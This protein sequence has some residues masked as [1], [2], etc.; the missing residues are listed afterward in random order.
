[1]KWV[2]GSGLIEESRQKSVTQEK[3]PGDRESYGHLSAVD[4]RVSGARD[5]LRRRSGRL[6][7]R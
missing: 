5:T 4:I 3:S 6:L 7:A 1:L 2:A